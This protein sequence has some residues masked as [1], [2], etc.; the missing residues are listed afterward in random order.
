MI[1]ANPT[2]LHPSAT[3]LLTALVIGV[4][5]LYVIFFILFFS[6]SGPRDGDQFLV[7]HILQYWNSVLFGIAKQWTPLLCSVLSLAGEPQI[8]FISLSMAL[9]YV[10]G[11]LWGVRTSTAIYLAV[12]WGPYLYAAAD[13]PATCAGRLAIHRQWILLLSV[14]L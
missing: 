7:F 10:W 1:S 8:P 5:V 6:Q 14:G 9:S 2:R 3:K 4:V 12:G 11:P 13:L